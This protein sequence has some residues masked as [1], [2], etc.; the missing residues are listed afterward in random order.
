MEDK[1]VPQS[2]EEAVKQWEEENNSSLVATRSNSKVVG[3]GLIAL[4]VV[5]LGLA[6]YVK[7]SPAQ[8]D[9]SNAPP[10]EVEIAE[11]KPVQKL[12]QETTSPA[13]PPPTE[14]PVQIVDQQAEQARM[15]KAELERRMLEARLKSSLL[16]QGSN[17]PS[18]NSSPNSGSP[19]NVPASMFGP[20]SEKGPQDANSK[21][22]RSVSGQGVPS[23]QAR[24]LTNLEYKILQGKLIEAVLEPRAISDLPGMVCAVVQRDVYAHQGRSKLIP[25]GSKVCGVYSGDLRKGQ[26]RL[27]IVWNTL[28]RP[29]GIEVT[30][31]SV[32][33][34]QLGSVGLGGQVDT[35]FA[36]IFGMSALLSIIGA[37]ASTSGVQSSDQQ[38]SESYY[39]QSVQQAAAQTAQQVLQ[40]YAN[41]PPT[42]TV[43]AGSK[44][45]IYVNQD[46]DFSAVNEEQTSQTTQPN[47][48]F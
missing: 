24:Q 33:A 29:D 39:R 35:H 18:G 45:R 38:N 17:A 47:F 48:I 25:W 28:R 4:T 22:A 41:I 5:A 21:F 23:S 46:L 31:D 30:L 8:T 36:E 11:R 3:I 16:A 10:R 6:W 7:N 2:R 13:A 43:P 34:D 14:T 40:P 32:G 20:A 19:Q 12:P 44:V 1:P 27:F 9:P 15:Q 42:V 37:G 26:E